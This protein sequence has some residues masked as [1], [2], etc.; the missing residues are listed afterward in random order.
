M[1]GRIAES[2]QFADNALLKLLLVK[3]NG[4]KARRPKTDIM[5]T[6]PCIDNAT[7]LSMMLRIN[8]KR[9]SVCSCM[10]PS[11]RAKRSGAP[12]WPVGQYSVTSEGAFAYAGDMQD[13]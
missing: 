8:V 13:E 4:R 7:A 11:R 12:Y 3:P 10:R 5:G 6:K 1:S 9:H 2:T